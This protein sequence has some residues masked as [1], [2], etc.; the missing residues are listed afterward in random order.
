MAVIPDQPAQHAH[1]AAPATAS[2]SGR[3]RMRASD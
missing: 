1:G 2:G 3:P